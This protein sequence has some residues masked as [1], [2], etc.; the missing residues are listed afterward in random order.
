MKEMITWP[1]QQNNNGN[2]ENHQN[3][4]MGNKDD[5]EIGALSTFKSMMEAEDV[6]WYNMNSNQNNNRGWW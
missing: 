2:N 3:G 1:V 6:H 5:M 4:V